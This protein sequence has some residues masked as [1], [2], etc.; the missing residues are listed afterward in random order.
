MSAESKKHRT[1]TGKGRR[2]TVPT[3]A[4]LAKYSA[5]VEGETVLGYLRVLNKSADN[6]DYQ[7]ECECLGQEGACKKK[8]VIRRSILFKDFGAQKSCG[9]MTNKRDQNKKRLAMLTSRHDASTLPVEIYNLCL[10][11]KWDKKK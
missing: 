11:Q 8:I 6:K 4:L 1:L 2:S 3:P 9:C 5:V 10:S 7:W